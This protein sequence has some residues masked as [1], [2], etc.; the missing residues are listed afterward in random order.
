MGIT[1]SEWLETDAQFLEAVHLATGG[2]GA[3]PLQ[4]ILMMADALDGIVL[5][6]KETEA[7]VEKL[8]AAKLL[9]VVK[10][11]LGL[12]PDFLQLYDDLDTF[13]A[14][15]VSYSDLL[16]KAE[17]TLN[18][19]QEARETLKKVKLKNQYQQYLEQNG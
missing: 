12:T 3:A 11:K 14:S 18:N 2:E 4:E 19:V 7:A 1:K 13:D 9:F 15:E 10:N 16:L 8:I 6:W 5:T 17:L